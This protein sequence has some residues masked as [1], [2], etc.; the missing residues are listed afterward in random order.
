MLSAL[1]DQIIGEGAATRGQIKAL[2]E[3]LK[4]SDYLPYVNYDDEVQDYFTLDNRFGHLYECTPLVFKSMETI[5]NMR[6][7]VKSS[8]PRNTVI[9][10]IQHGSPHIKPFIDAHNSLMTTNNPIAQRAREEK[11][12]MLLNFTEGTS[13]LFGNPIRHIR[14][15]F[16]ITCQDPL[17]E[18]QLAIFEN[19]I[20]SLNI[21]PMNVPPTRLREWMSTFFGYE[22]NTDLPTQVS[23]N[24][25]IRKQIAN[26]ESVVEFHPREKYVDLG[27]KFGRCITPKFLPHAI[28]AIE[29]NAL[30]GGYM[31]QDDDGKQIQGEY[32]FT[33]TIFMGEENKEISEKDQQTVKAQK[34]SKQAAK[35]I[36]ELVWA[37]KRKDNGE[38]F[39]KVIP[40]LWIFEPTVEKLNHSTTRAIKIW[41][42]LEGCEMQ[43]ETIL[44]KIMF[45]SAF[46]FGLYEPEK[47]IST[48]DRHFY[49]DSEAVATLAPITGD[50]GGVGQPVSLFVGRKGQLCTFDLFAKEFESFNFLVAAKTGGGKS[51]LLNS[52]VNDN[53]SVGR[54]VRI[55]S[56]GAD[57]KKLS[58]LWDGRYLDVNN[59]QLNPFYTSGLINARDAEDE[60]G[61]LEAIRAVVCEMAFGVNKSGQ[62]NS[63]NT[64]I[65]HAVAAAHQA[66]DYEYPIDAV[67]KFL[68]GWPKNMP[69]WEGQEDI[70][71]LR[72]KAQE[73][74]F[75]LSPFMSNG[76]Y[77]KLFCGKSQFD[78]SSDQLVILELAKFAKS[79]QLLSVAYLQ[80]MNAF[81]TDLYES[82]RSEPR[83]LLFEEFKTLMMLLGLDDKSN[84]KQV[85]E[86]GYRRARKY[87]GALGVVLQSILDVPDFGDLGK[88]FEENS[89]TKFLLKS[90]I[91]R[92]ASKQ[93][94]IEQAGIALELL[95]SVK[96]V[97]KHYAE[98]F[99]ETNVGQG[100]M[101]SVLDKFNMFV[102]SSEGA[103]FEQYEEAINQGMNPFEALCHLSQV[104]YD[105]TL[106]DKRAD[107]A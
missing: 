87:T 80:V 59:C 33:F 86:E 31:G 104:P 105:P 107:A 47:N 106:W 26:A 8:L 48:I 19:N 12:K 78:I 9:Q 38:D 81:T 74:A 42:S 63:D 34:L 45:I 6:A 57:Y 56:M 90:D 99:I 65:E 64:L 3:R 32:L 5:K 43:I 27:N 100:V 51:N 11:T 2:V 77:G 7:L 4:M 25:P 28:D 14:L 94:A 97:K 101:R 103:E 37:D 88:A 54:A 75:N 36:E 98:L 62:T 71:K 61:A 96:L 39:V 24:M 16:A 69:E 66:G 73:I 50:F 76:R 53:L 20:K 22:D 95:D 82:K 85:V 91:Y 41:E 58:D 30:L 89:N 68:R 52:L 49:V 72:E 40:Q 102:N 21:R 70:D 79:K 55:A 67:Y 18:E 1:K 10:V 29:A 13:Q 83:I 35:R 93:G 23:A 84:F 15:F 60:S 17:T 46:P 44:Q 92:K